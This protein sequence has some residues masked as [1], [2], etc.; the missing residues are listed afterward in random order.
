MLEPGLDFSV[1]EIGERSLGRAFGIAYS[2]DRRQ[3][4][5]DGYGIILG[6]RVSKDMGDQIGGM[7]SVEGPA[8]GI[9]RREQTILCMPAKRGGLMFKE[10]W[11]SGGCL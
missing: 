1:V 9:G 6:G 3:I 2:K 10:T 7:C 8:G 5:K 4:R 11:K